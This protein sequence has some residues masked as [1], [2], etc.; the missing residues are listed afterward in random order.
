MKPEIIKAVFEK[1]RIYGFTKDDIIV[2]ALALT[3]S[4]DSRS[5]LE[6][7]D[8]IEWCVQVF[9]LFRRGLWRNRGGGNA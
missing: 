6:A 9:K 1:A 7:L 5:A 8:T 4:A 2:D 3:V